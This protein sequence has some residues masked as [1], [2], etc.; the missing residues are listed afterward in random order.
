[1]GLLLSS[2]APR[3]PTPL[4]GAGVVGEEAAAAA[5]RAAPGAARE[6]PHAPA[7]GAGLLQRSTL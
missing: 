1:M 4:L 6:D 7:V 2:F 3:H 5:P